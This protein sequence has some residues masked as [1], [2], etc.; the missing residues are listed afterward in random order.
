MGK[1]DL[2]EQIKKK[3]DRVNF[4][5]H[6]KDLWYQIKNST[7]FLNEQ[8]VKKCF[9]TLWESKK[10]NLRKLSSLSNSDQT[11]WDLYFLQLFVS[12]KLYL[13]LEI[14]LRATEM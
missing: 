7:D 3:S 13:L 5:S 10:F 14:V 1:K 4:G 6:L 11:P 9:G 2:I 12:F 8:S